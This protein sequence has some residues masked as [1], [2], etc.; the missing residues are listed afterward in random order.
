M[1]E[2]AD[3]LERQKGDTYQFRLIV[4]PEDG[5][6]MADLKP[7]VRD[8]MRDMEEDLRTKLDWVAV[9]HFNT[10]HPHT[11]IIIAGH[12]DR[13][14]D[15]VMAR[16]YIS[17]GIRHRA[18][19]L[20]TLELGPEQQ[21]E[22]IIKLANEIKA[23]RFTSLDRGILKD[24]RENVLVVSAM[25]DGARGRSE[26]REDT[27]HSLRVGRLRRLEVMGLAE[28]KQTGVWA[29]DPNLETKLRSL[30][31]RGDIMVIMN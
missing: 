17:H 8:L 29:I 2:G 20:V 18:Q 25:P 12:D 6:R 30:G 15:L 24:A 10:G 3:F 21:F 9:D 31:Q 7:F 14:Q 22:R 23:E 11:H 1:A 4:A 13:G 5:D 27:Q 26:R 16:H 28:E 19:D